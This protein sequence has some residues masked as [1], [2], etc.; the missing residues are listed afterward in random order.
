MTLKNIQAL[1]KTIIQ[2]LSSGKTT[3]MEE[4]VYSTPTKRTTRS[5]AAKLCETPLTPSKQR[6]TKDHL[7]KQAE[8]AILS[9]KQHMFNLLY[10]FLSFLFFNFFLKFE[11]KKS[12]RS[13]RN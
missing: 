1:Y 13:G 6:A 2:E 9:Y 10:I 5:S 7:A 12:S 3:L 8:T 11:T 4:N